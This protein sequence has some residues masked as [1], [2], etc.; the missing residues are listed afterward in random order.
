[1]KK[2]MFTNCTMFLVLGLAATQTIASAQA[3]PGLEG[4]WLGEIA[5]VDCHTGMP[6]PGVLSF[7]VLH[8]FGHDGSFTN[9]SANFVATPASRRSSG[10][11]RWEHTQ[12]Q[13]YT[14]AFQFFVYNPDES[15]MVLR[16][17]SLTITLA[18]N[19]FTSVNQSQDYLVNFANGITLTPIPG[20]SGCNTQKAIRLQ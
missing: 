18:G 15:F 5:P 2:Y 4:V 12:A 10:V 20:A 14:A 6:I 17:V 19:Y 8:M 1:M 7:P 9:E 11:G 13:T 3:T 16:K